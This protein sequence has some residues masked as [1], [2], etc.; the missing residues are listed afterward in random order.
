VQT[1]PNT[2]AAVLAIALMSGSTTAIAT[3]IITA[4][5][6]MGAAFATAPTPPFNPGFGIRKEFTAVGPLRHTFTVG[7]ES[8]VDRIGFDIE[9]LIINRTPIDFADLVST[10][11]DSEGWGV[12]FE[13]LAPFRPPPGVVSPGTVT[14]G[15]GPFPDSIVEGGI[16]LRI[17]DPSPGGSYRFILVETPIPVSVPEP[18]TLGL[19]GTGL[20]VFDLLH[21]PFRLRPH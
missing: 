3:P 6:S 2:P 10:I 8:G 14:C 21:R 12:T 20:L 9:E 1:G 15:A 13:Q 4:V 17:P 19:L 7:H 18:A 16:L 5:E 11:E